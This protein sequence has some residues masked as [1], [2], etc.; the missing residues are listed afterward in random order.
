MLPEAG[1]VAAVGKKTGSAPEFLPL[2]KVTEI[3]Y[4][5]AGGSVAVINDLPVMEGTM[6]NDG[7]VDKILADRVRL[8]I[9]GEALDILLDAHP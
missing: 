4:Q 6:V 3:Y 1:S 7:R 9:D 8:I 2:Y 5:D